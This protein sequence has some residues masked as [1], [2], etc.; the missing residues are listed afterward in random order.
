MEAKELRNLFDT[1]IRSGTTRFVIDLSATDY[2]SSEALGTIAGCFNA[3]AQQISGTLSVILPT[4]ENNEVRNLFDII[5]LS[6]L[7][8]SAIQTSRK[9]ALLYI[10]DLA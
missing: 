1:A 2:I 6:R 9:D 10:R 4:E 8:G 5:G 3:C 7:M